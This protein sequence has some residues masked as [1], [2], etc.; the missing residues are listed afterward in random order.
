[1]RKCLFIAFLG[2]LFIHV[3][4]VGQPSIN[5]DEYAVIQTDRADGRFVSSRGVTHAL[6]KHNV[7]ELAFNQ[8]FTKTQMKHWQ[9]KMSKAMEDLMKHPKING[10][11]EPRM[12]S[13]VQR[14]GYRVEKWE[15]YPLPE[16]VVPYLVLIPDTIRTGEKV[17]AVLCIPGTSQSKEYAASEPEVS[18]RYGS[19]KR[20]DRY[21]MALPF[22]RKGLIAVVVDNPGTAETSDLEKYTIAPNYQYDHVARFLLE[23]DWSYLGYSSYCAMHVLN[24]MKL[25]PQIRKDRLIV[26]GFSLGTEPLMALGLMDSSIYAFVYNDFV[27]R[28][29]ERMIVLTKPN[30]K[31][32]RPLPNSIMHLIPGF[33]TKFDFPDIV[34]ALAP[35]PVICPEGGLDRDLDMIRKAYQIMGAGDNVEIHHYAKFADVPRE[36]CEHLPEGIDRPTF[37]Q[38]TNVDPPQHDMKMK[39]IIPWLDKVLKNAQ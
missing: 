11:P 29:L 3:H 35:R 15:S 2:L 10:L 38:L 18:D 8:H 13:Q 33:L 14:D 36:Q 39:W 1:M 4:T 6:L 12:I 28:T 7:P 25:H 27:C 30:D 32:I 23:L 22:V 37:F 9:Q 31:G 26:C 34:A 24:W 19:K 21:L 16:C 5:P 20:Q 17:P